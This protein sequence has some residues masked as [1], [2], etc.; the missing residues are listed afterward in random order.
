MASVF[1]LAGE[2]DGGGQA[3]DCQ[4]MHDV[5]GDPRSIH[6]YAGTADHGIALLQNQADA[7]DKLFDWL[8]QQL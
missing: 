7:D 3:T 4:T 6:I 1:Y 5:S 2:N 8:S